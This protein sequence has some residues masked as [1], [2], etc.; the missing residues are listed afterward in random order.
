[1]R[2]EWNRSSAQC[3]HAL[4]H[5]LTCG[6]SLSG[7]APGVCGRASS[8]RVGRARLTESTG[9]FGGGRFSPSSSS[10]IMLSVG[11]SRPIMS[12]TSSSSAF[13][14]APMA[15]VD[16]RLSRRACDAHLQNV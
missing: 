13:A 16:L 11:E 6:W 5:V 3:T 10:A 9:V 8:G 12:Y 1:M 4:T 14:D 2:V 15:P 7:W